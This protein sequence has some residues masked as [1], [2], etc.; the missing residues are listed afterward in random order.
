MVEKSAQEQAS[1]VAA[2]A[3]S[4]Q[5]A[6][7]SSA[8]KIALLVIVLV[9]IETISTLILVA[10]RQA[11][12]LSAQKELESTQAALK[13]PSVAKAVVQVDN[14]QAAITA[15]QKYA[16]SQFNYD[17]LFNAFE[18]QLLPSVRLDSLTFDSKNKI[19]ATAKTK[20]YEDVARQIKVFAA[21]PSLSDLKLG[22]IDKSGADVRFTLT[23]SFKSAKTGATSTATTP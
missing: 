11:A 4:Y 23:G 19:T 15:Y 2:T 16:Q 3:S 18:T 6:G 21:S 9:V 5:Q 12:Q 22:T 13:V 10:N 7:L 20:S 1:F 17:S 14:A 8:G